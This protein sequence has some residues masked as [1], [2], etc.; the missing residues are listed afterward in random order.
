MSHPV[1]EAARHSDWRPTRAAL[2]LAYGVLGEP[3]PSNIPERDWNLTIALEHAFIDRSEWT[4]LECQKKIP[5]RQEIVCLDCGAP[6]HKLCAERH[7]WPKGRPSHD[8][9]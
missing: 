7:F 1:L 9:S 3:V 2:E 4:C 5:Y 6:L 8:R